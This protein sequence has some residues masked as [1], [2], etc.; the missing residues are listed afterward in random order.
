MKT[1]YA[2][3]RFSSDNQREE[4]IEAQFYEIKKYAE[5]E[6]I[7]IK[8]YYSDEAIS[9]L[10]SN[11][12]QFKEMINDIMDNG[13]VDYVIVYKVDRFSRNKYQSAIYKE[14]LS[15]IGVKV[16]YAAQR[17]SDTPEGGLM[18][19]ILE[20]FA[21]YY[22]DNLS[23]DTRRGQYNNARNG[24][25]NGGRPPLGYFIDD[26][27]R[28]RIDPYEATI[29]KSIFDMYLDGMSQS[30]IARELN[31]KGYKTREKMDFSQTSISRIL[32]NKK[33]IGIYEHGRIQVKYNT[34]GK[35]TL[36]VKRPDEEVVINYD[37]IPPIIDKDV[38]YKVQKMVK[39]RANQK[40]VKQ[41]HDY[42][43]R[44]LIFCECGQKMYGYT[45]ARYPSNSRYRCKKC[46][47]A[48][49]KEALE[50]Y[51]MSVARNYILDNADV[52]VDR[53]EQETKKALE[54]RDTDKNAL[55]K[56]LDEIDKEENNCVEYV[57]SFGANE[58]IRSKIEELNKEKNEINNLLAS[59]GGP[60]N[61]KKEIRIWLNKIKNNNLALNKKEFIQ[62]LVRKVVVSREEVQIF[63]NIFARPSNTDAPAR[64]ATVFFSHY[65]LLKN[66]ANHFLKSFVSFFLVFYELGLGFLCPGPNLTSPTRSIDLF[67]GYKYRLFPGFQLFSPNFSLNYKFLW[68]LFWNQLFF[69]ICF[70]FL[71]SRLD[72][73]LVQRLSSVLFVHNQDRLLL[74][75]LIFF[76]QLALLFLHRK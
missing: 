44:G 31:E 13:K 6:G 63:F 22:S 5:S 68:N 64:G 61:I 34:T 54:S 23:T 38:F 21:Q 11:R 8:N 58:K 1:A 16:L 57:M 35:K 62:L 20:S 14:K 24:L 55:K 36:E 50:K 70:L 49:K 66:T 9:G 33:Y 53:I 69:L 3:A 59:T 40:A 71:P 65:L 76:C 46:N 25:F 48:I 43:L 72:K 30:E 37:A 56:R 32:T 10:T 42:P 27:K 74:P 67:L 18:E 2:Y 47:N 7:L 75:V 52:L 19:G 4:S 17:L 39:D 41:R 15:R 12:P 45:D 26:E 28:Y 29:V 73:Y 51:I 60:I